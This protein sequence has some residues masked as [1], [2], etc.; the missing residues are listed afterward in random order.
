MTAT[1][2]TTDA[3]SSRTSGRSLHLNKVGKR[4]GTATA[5]DDVTLSVEPGTFLV[6]LGPSGSGK[7]TLLRGLA[8]IERF[9]TGAVR[10]GSTVIDD[11][12]THVPTE[13]RGLAMVFQ[14]YAL[15]PHLTVRQN[16]AYAL[17]RHHLDRHEAARRVLDTL[18]RVGISAKAD[19]YPQEL[20]GG[21]QQRV[22]LARAIVGSPALLLFDEPLSNLDADL[23]EHLRV[24]IATITRESGATAVYIT[25]D[26]AE[27]FALADV[28]GVLRDGRL[29]QLGAP[30]SI[31]TRPATPF[32]ARFTGLAGA[33]A[34]TVVGRFD[35]G[36]VAVGVG[37]HRLA[38]GIPADAVLDTGDDVDVLIRGAALRLDEPAAD[39]ATGTSGGGVPGRVTDVAYR[40][41]GY[42]HV[43]ATAH[44]ALSGIFAPQAW[45]RGT[46]CRVVI[47]PAGC[48]AFPRRVPST[49]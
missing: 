18:D 36:T 29:E 33:F 9:D 15:W 45:S 31:Y 2:M 24:E 37:D 48:F 6:M 47:D 23:R 12:R 32:V 43:V 10:F 13:R 25:H 14:D 3:S 7:T 49:I 34:G 20:S 1:M 41:R 19:A 21:Q 4:F 17:K 40:G 38:A 42:E 16:V 22:A 44:G 26:Q 39:A 11:G 5:L 46:E 8:G 35:V 28:V 27:A 30:E